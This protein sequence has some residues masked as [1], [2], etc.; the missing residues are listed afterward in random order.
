MVVCG[1]CVDLIAEHNLIEI[2]KSLCGCNSKSKNL[3]KKNCG[4]LAVGGLWVIAIHRTHLSAPQHHYSKTRV[5]QSIEELQ[6]GWNSRQRVVPTSDWWGLF[7]QQV[8]RTPRT[9]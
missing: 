9:I 8:H 5:E 7:V 2:N 1:G 4:S 3:K 6:Y